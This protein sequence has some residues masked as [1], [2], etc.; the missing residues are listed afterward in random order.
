MGRPSLIEASAVR[1]A[2]GQVEVMIKGSA[3]HVAQGTIRV[4]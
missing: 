2:D 3:V 1:G 4:P